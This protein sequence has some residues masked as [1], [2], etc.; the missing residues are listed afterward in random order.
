MNFLNNEDW[1]SLKENCLN[2]GVLI[3]RIIKSFYKRA[4]KNTDTAFDIGAHVGYHT[5]GLVERLTDGIVIACE[6]NPKTYLE[7]LKNLSKIRSSTPIL[8]VNAAIQ[9]DL[10]KKEATFNVSAEHPGRS[11]LVRMWKSVTYDKVTVT[12][13]TLDEIYTSLGLQKLDFIKCDVEGTEWEVLVG[14]KNAIS[15][16]RPIIVLE[17]GDRES[18][19]FSANWLSFFEKNHLIPYFPNGER[20]SQSNFNDFWYVFIFP[21]E[22]S[23]QLLRQLE[24]AVLSWESL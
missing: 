6:G 9:D 14:A 1:N 21:K 19:N 5:I 2:N 7:L 13:R 18:E 8:T 11:G 23:K 17:H 22:R 4:L 12:A 15:K 16:H 10:D 24:S 20:V 3:E